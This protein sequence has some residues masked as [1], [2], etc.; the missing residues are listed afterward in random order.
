MARS[1]QVQPE[2]QVSTSPLL[3]GFLVLAALLVSVGMVAV[4]S[5]GDDPTFVD[6]APP[7]AERSPDR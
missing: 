5:S 3:I 4:A 6:P 1:L 7:R 2:E